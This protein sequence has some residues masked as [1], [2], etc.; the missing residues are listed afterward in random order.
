MAPISSWSAVDVHPDSPDPVESSGT[1]RVGILSMTNL[2]FIFLLGLEAGSSEPGPG[3]QWNAIDPLMLILV[4]GTGIG[5]LLVGGRLL[6]P[7][8]VLAAASLGAVV[9]L[10]LATGTRQET[11]PGWLL[12]QGIPSLVWVAGL[13]LIMGIISMIIARFVLAVMLGAA[14]ATAVLVLGLAIVEQSE[15]DAASVVRVSL[16]HVSTVDVD[17]GDE[18]AEI[19]PADTVSDAVTQAVN[20]AVMESMLDRASDLA[21]GVV[22]DLSGWSPAVPGWIRTWWSRSTAGVPPSTIDLLVALA[23]VSAICAL[24]LGLLLP[25]RTAIVATSIAGA[26]LLSAAL[27]AAWSRFGDGSPPPPFPSL[28]GGGLLAG[29]GILIQHRWA[30]RAVVRT[31]S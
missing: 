5:L 20:D 17:P 10:R 15:P 12:A 3:G 24:L 13:P 9:G 23:S 22:G 25:D 8:V 14:T 29:V 27:A 26:W 21:D 7:A 11:L 19:E 6:K 16:A 4:A 18:D 1:R 31:E 28:L 30:P 2:V